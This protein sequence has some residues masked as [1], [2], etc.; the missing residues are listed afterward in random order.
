MITNGIK[1]NLKIG[2]KVWSLN[3]TCG[4]EYIIVRFTEKRVVCREINTANNGKTH[5]LS[6]HC[7]SNLFLVE[8]VKNKVANEIL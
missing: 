4:Q 8:T 2:Q 7:P 1:H 3:C 5:A 6:S